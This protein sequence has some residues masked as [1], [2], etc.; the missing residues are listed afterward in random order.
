M[1]DVAAVGVARPRDVGTAVG[2]GVA[3]GVQAAEEFAVGAELVEYGAADA[4]HDAH[5]A[6]DV[7]AVGQLDADARD[8]GADGA[9]AEGDDVHGAAAHGA[10]VEGGHLGLHFG[11]VAPV[12]VGAG[13]AGVGGADEGAVLDARDVGGIG[14]GQV[15]AGALGF[16]QADE[17]ALGDEL[18]GEGVVLGLGAVAPV[19]G[20]GLAEG[21]DFGDPVVEGG[22][23][24]F[25]HGA[26]LHFRPRGGGRNARSGG[27]GRTVARGA[28]ARQ[29]KNR[30]NETPGRRPGTGPR[31]RRKGGWVSTR[32]GAWRW[33]EGRFRSGR[34]P[35]S[36]R[37][38]PWRGSGGWWRSRRGPRG[39]RSPG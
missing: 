30:G 33:R 1:G 23:F 21:G 3:D 20:V 35:W 32:G 19:D 18:R 5:V 10:A 7:G 39:G 4:G 12:V 6:G 37:R 29:A 16:V 13:L 36:R 38:G 17:G 8:G 2:Q 22:V 25:D 14:A 26:Y 11:G 31:W 28:G 27:E 15:G 24:A 9:H 34:V